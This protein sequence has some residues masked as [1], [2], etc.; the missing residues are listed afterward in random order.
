MAE[1]TLRKTKRRRKKKNWKFRPSLDFLESPI[2]GPIH[3]NTFILGA[4]NPIEFPV[5]D[6]STVGWISP[7]FHTRTVGETRSKLASTRAGRGPRL[8]RRKHKSEQVQSQV[9]TN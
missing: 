6:H 1:G 8:L 2:N 4:S 3:S 5:K 9:Q 7:V